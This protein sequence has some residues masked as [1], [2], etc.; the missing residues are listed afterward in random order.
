VRGYVFF[1]TLLGK[2]RVFSRDVFSIVNRRVADL[3]TFKELFAS[4]TM[5]TDLRSVSTILSLMDIA[6]FL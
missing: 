5:Q 4:F 6:Q 3:R 2:F 1:A